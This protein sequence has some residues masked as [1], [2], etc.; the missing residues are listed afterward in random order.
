MLRA[1]TSTIKVMVV[2]FVKVRFVGLEF[3]EL[4]SAPLILRAKFEIWLVVICVAILV[5]R[6]TGVQ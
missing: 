3:M 4:R 2:A 5:V 6:Q 1:S